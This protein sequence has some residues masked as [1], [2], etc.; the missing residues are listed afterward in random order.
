MERGRNRRRTDFFPILDILDILSRS[1]DI[2]DR[3]LKLSEIAPNFACFW[4]LIS[5]G[6]RPPN[7]W[8]CIIKNTHT[9]IMWQSFAAIG[10]RSSE[11]A[12]RIKKT[13]RVKHKAFGTNVPGGLMKG[14][15]TSKLFK[16]WH[17]SGEIL[18]RCKQIWLKLRR[19]MLQET[20][21][22]SSSARTRLSYY[23]R[24]SAN[25]QTKT[26]LI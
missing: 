18:R 20:I 10:R 19:P 25:N 16:Y 2:R 13:S 7:F 24:P 26:N 3:I 12:R 11:V 22:R 21:F 4:P 5:L 15:R 1:G 17:V 23:Q 6:G 9:A 14:D 8:T